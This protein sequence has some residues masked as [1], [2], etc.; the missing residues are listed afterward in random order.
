MPRLGNANRKDNA[1]QKFLAL[2]DRDVDEIEQNDQFEEFKQIEQIERL[3]EDKSKKSKSV[4]EEVAAALLGGTISIDMYVDL[5]RLKSGT[6]KSN[7]VEALELAT[8]SKPALVNKKCLDFVTAS[9]LDKEPRTKREA[10]RVIANCCEEFST[11]LELAVTNLQR[12]VRD[13]G[14]VVRWSVALALSEI[15]KGSAYPHKGRLLGQLRENEEQE[16]KASIKKIYKAAL[17]GR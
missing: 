15:A 3:L 5:A 11:E 16:E 9:L 12:N 13:G 8:R 6:N 10:A 4:I 2:G 17:E 14:A 7:L 1:G